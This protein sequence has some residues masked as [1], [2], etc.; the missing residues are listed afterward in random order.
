MHRIYTW[1]VLSTGDE[2]AIAITKSSGSS[3]RD[4]YSVKIENACQLSRHGKEIASLEVGE[5]EP[6]YCT[7]KDGTELDSVFLRPLNG[8][9]KPWPTVVVVHGGPYD[10]VT[11]SF[12]QPLYNWGAW[13]VA[14]GYAVLYPNYRGSS[15][16]GEKFA[17][18]A[19]GGMGTTDYDDIISTLKAAISAGLVDEHRVA[20]A[21]WSQGEFLS[22]LAVTRP[23]FHFK[24]AICGAG[25]TSWDAMCETSHEVQYETELTGGAPWE[26]EVTSL[27]GRQGSAIWHMKNVKTP[28]LIMH[29]EKDTTVPVEQAIAFHRG[30]LH[31]KITCEMVTYP[32]EG[33]RIFE[34]YHYLDMLN[35]IRKFCDLHLKS[36]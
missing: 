10:R 20:I 25:V 5:A 29:G 19:R 26:F 9:I 16:R 11:I 34:R 8:S 4:I 32:Q 1:D 18:A 36:E 33:H 12:E 14:A 7:A 21:G 27:K 17:S 28:I 3:P 13:L 24:A 6:F 15:S 22:Y 30:C 23:D 2:H 31:Y 35:R